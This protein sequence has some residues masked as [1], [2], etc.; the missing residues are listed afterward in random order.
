MGDNP[1]R[2][3]IKKNQVNGKDKKMRTIDRVWNDDGHFDRAMDQGW[4][5]FH[6]DGGGMDGCREIQ[7][8]ADENK[9][10]SDADAMRFVRK[11]ATKGDKTCLLGLELHGMDEKE[12]LDM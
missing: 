10:R 7:A 5:L 4:N 8:V 11:M 12:P 9:F 2:F 3:S 1:T 6:C